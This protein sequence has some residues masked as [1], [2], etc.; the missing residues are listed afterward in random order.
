MYDHSQQ[1]A[2]PIPSTTALS[3]ESPANERQA[4][5]SA[6]KLT[7]LRDN[8]TRAACTPSTSARPQLEHVLSE[9]GLQLEASTRNSMGAWFGQDFSK[10]RIHDNDQ[11]ASVAGEL[12]AAALTVGNHIIF[13]H[14]A[15]APDSLLGRKIFAHELTHIVQQRDSK[16]RIA[17]SPQQNP[18]MK[19]NQLP[20]AKIDF[21]GRSKRW[22]VQIGGIPVAEISAEG[23]ESEISIHVNVDE[24]GADITVR[25]SGQASMARSV[26]ASSTL[27][28]PVRL[29]EIDTSQSPTGSTSGLSPRA[30]DSESGPPIPLRS[31]LRPSGNAPWISVRG[32]LDI[33]ASHEEL[34]EWEIRLRDEGRKIHG[35]VVDPD[36]P[37]LVIG[38]QLS[39][40]SVTQILDREGNLQHISEPGIESPFLDP[41]DF[42][43]SPGSVGKVATG[44]GSKVFAKSVGKILGKEAAAMGPALPRATIARLRQIAAAIA[45]R[46]GRKG[47]EKATTAMVRKITEGGL[48]HSFDRHAAEWF[49]RI[50]SK[51]THLALWR[52]MVERVGAS[53]QAFRWSLGSDSTIAHLGRIDDRYFV[54]QFFEKT[55][56][57]ATAFVP[58]QKQLARWL[59]LIRE[60][61]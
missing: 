5:E 31:I 38:Y 58:N 39:P 21:D 57:F 7:G 22:I 52:Q 33:E 10:V 29:T 13:G 60:I 55:G 16:Q 9:Q 43:P 51:E 53:K 27:S 46:G 61:P 1:P 34:T 20:E 30:P 25:H 28:I 42:I 18:L 54:V 11:S 19:T 12:G 47:V 49:G 17:L 8:H 56:E 45:R 40:G 2:D 50:V 32:E 4:V 37:D 23:K 35:V 24:A 41:I 59:E 14:G 48:L 3:H 6:A 36:N 26:A 44:V 15:Y